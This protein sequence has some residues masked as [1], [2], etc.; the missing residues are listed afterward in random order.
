EAMNQRL[1]N[2]DTS[3]QVQLSPKRPT[4]HGVSYCENA[5]LGAVL[6][7]A[8]GDKKYLKASVNAV[9]KM[10][11]F[12]MLVDGVPSSSE[13]LRGKVPLDSHEACVISDFTWSCGYLLMATGEGHYGD[14]IERACFN[15][16]PGGV[17]KD[18]RA[19]QYFSCPNQV[20]SDKNSNHN[21]FYRGTI[22][23]RFAPN[24]ATECCAGNVNRFMP[25]F[26]ARMWMRGADDEIVAALYG[27]G[28]LT[29]KVGKADVTIVEETDYPFADRIEF[30]VRT[31]AP[32]AFALTLR[33]PAWCAKPAVLVNGQPWKTKPKPGAF[34]TVRRTFA[35]NDRVTLVLPMTLKLTHWPHGGIA[36]ERGPLVYSLKIDERWGVDPSETKKATAEFPAWGVYP[37]SPWNYA[38]ELDAKKLADQVEVVQTGAA[39]NPWTNPPIIL[40]VPARRVKGWTIDARRVVRGQGAGGDHKLT[41]RFLLT[42]QLP[43][44]AGLPKRL[45]AKRET[46]TLVP[47]G[48]THLRISVFPQA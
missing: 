25:N 23:M 10:E 40:R 33:I 6:Y 36:L 45:S 20:V 30:Q 18:F 17:K 3:L 7:G 39:G 9:A 32:A 28:R 29:T 31:S 12:A 4:E 44:P 11:K 43:D 19:A 38:L 42:P 27:P 16:G 21:E 8:T 2:E 14:L 46:V 26:A 15:A 5:K 37:E 41:G 1:P 24:P 34:L 47:Y 48:C 13:K 35:N 22:F